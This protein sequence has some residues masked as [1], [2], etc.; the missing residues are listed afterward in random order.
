VATRSEHSTVSARLS[1]AS[2]GS[3]VL[4]AGSVFFVVASFLPW[5]RVCTDDMCASATAWHGV[6]ILAGL[7]GFAV[8]VLEALRLLGVD[9]RLD[10]PLHARVVTALAAGLLACT[11]I[12]ALVDAELRAYGSWLGV[13]AAALIVTGAVLAL[14]EASAA[15]TRERHH[16]AMRQ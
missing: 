8:L 4:L 1:Q 6:G 12:K 10:A 7:L 11:L 3:K 2:P 9:L 15:A 5:Q 14:A 13:I 16:A